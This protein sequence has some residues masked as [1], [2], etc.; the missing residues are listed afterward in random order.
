[1]RPSDYGI[2]DRYR[3]VALSHQI[4]VD[5]TAARFGVH[6]STV[7]YWRLESRLHNVLMPGRPDLMEARRP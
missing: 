7:K 5:A 1:M 6:P 2:A 3:A 4:G